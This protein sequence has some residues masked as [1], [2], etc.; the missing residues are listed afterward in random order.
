VL[1]VV[2]LRV[3]IS[4][5]TYGN[6]RPAL[7][8]SGNNFHTRTDIS[9]SAILTFCTFLYV[10]DKVV[11]MAA[12]SWQKMRLYFSLNGIFCTYLLWQFLMFVCQGMTICCVLWGILV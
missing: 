12:L 1:F 6:D 8:E 10:F 7:I 4:Y 2:R 5:C 11:K 3:V 9:E